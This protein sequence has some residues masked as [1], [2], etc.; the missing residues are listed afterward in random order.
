MRSGAEE[1]PLPRK[2]TEVRV[3][4]AERHDP[5]ER[6]Q[7]HEPALIMLEGDL[8][9]QVFRVHPGRQIIGRRPECD[10]R[11]RER[12]VSGIHAEVIRVRDTVT[13]NDLASTN[14]TLVNGMRIR[15]PVVLLQGALLKLGNCVFKFVDSLLE[16]E[17]TEALH[18]RGITDQ[19]TGT[20]NNAYL[21][22]RLGFLI[23]TASTEHPVGVITFDFDNFKQVNDQYGH[24]AG[25]HIL[26]A[27]SA[28]I[29]T[30]FVRDADIFARMGGEEFAIALPDTPLE[31]A[32]RIAERIRATLEE[33][34]FTY[35]GLAI[36]LTSSFGVCSA[37]AANEQPEAVLARADELLYRSKREGRNRVTS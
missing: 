6:A 3:E 15:T 9:G 33:Q 30:Q 2:T 35:D 19:L 34:T 23:D 7:T 21:L 36:K 18:A 20:F 13:I 32:A 26:R 10:I 37:T 25:D 31:L 11:V 5:V 16:V 1:K 12:A 28:L 29:T 8:P 27:T 17:F 22:A 14:G 4:T 24:A